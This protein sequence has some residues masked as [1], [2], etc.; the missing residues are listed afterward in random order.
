[1]A[2]KHVWLAL[3]L[4]VSYRKWKHDYPRLTWTGWDSYL[5]NP[6]GPFYRGLWWLIVGVPQADLDYYGTGGPT[7]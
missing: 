3:T 2:R 5:K 7:W 6:L 1:M 4:T